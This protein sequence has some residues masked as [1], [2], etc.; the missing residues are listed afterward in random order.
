MS[1]ITS[2]TLDEKKLAKE[3]G[4]KLASFPETSRSFKLTLKDDGNQIEV[5]VPAIARRALIDALTALG[6]GKFVTIVPQDSELTTVQAAAFLNVSRPYLIGLL[7]KGLIEYRMVGSHRR[8][9]FTSLQE[10][11]SDDLSKRKAILDKLAQEAQRLE[12]D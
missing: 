8:V 1:D 5:E 9:R 7:E 10:Y 11:K 2:L 6:D 4:R 3:S 12:L